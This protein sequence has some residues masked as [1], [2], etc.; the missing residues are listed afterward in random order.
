MNNF[1]KIVCKSFFA[2]FY[3]IKENGRGMW[4]SGSSKSSLGSD[5]KQKIIEHL[6]CI[7]YR[8]HNVSTKCMTY[9]LGN[10]N[11]EPLKEL[12]WRAKFDHCP[13][14][15]TFLAELLADELIGM[16]SDRPNTYICMNGVRPR[17][18]HVPSTTLALK[19][20][21]REKGSAGQKDHMISIGEKLGA[22]IRSFVSQEDPSDVLRISPRWIE[23]NGR[24][25]NKK[26][27]REDRIYGSME[28]FECDEYVNENRSVI[29]I[30]DILTTGATMKDARRALAEA[31]ARH[32]YSIVIAH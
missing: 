8:E 10:Y 12:I 29:L 1:W 22:L 18:V 25:E 5:L 28:K 32:I 14:S 4:I 9:Y 21:K 13:L 7:R 27:S 16:W 26:L 30:D 20:S 11:F 24:M 6:H 17:V 2:L 15:R 19:D 31:G 23:R 3:P